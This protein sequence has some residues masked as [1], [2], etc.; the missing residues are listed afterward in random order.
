MRIG[1]AVD[2]T[3]DLPESFIRDN[4]IEILPITIR[5]GD[6]EIVDTHSEEAAREFYRSHIG[7]KGHDAESVPYTTEQICDTFLG[8]LVTEFDYVFCQTVMRTRSPIFE[9]ATKAS[10]S[11]LSQ[12]HEARKQAAVE[13][14]FALRVI[15]TGTVFTGQGVLAAETMR[16]IKA[17]MDGNH[18]R[19]S[20]DSLINCVRA[21]AVPPDLY[22]VRARARKK[23]DRSV[24]LVSAAL[25]SALD[26]KPIL[27]GYGDETKPV[28]KV[29]GFEPALEKLF[30]YAIR[31][32]EMGLMVPYLS[33]SYAGEL[34]DLSQF[35]R[36][37]DL[38][39]TCEQHEITLL[40]S[41]MSVTGGVN[42]GPGALSLALIAEPHT[43]Q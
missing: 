31:R 7:D 3:C 40:E 2:S 21:Y 30:N 15:N 5:L 13:G 26:I 29:R 1:L 19:K 10:F 11:I 35:P 6:T 4:N 39:T 33:I 42:I 34:D 18:I 38:K 8:R 14:P 22:Y 37:A 9:N 41:V 20:L 36:Y 28:D 12:Y 27:C 25:G 16:M 43:F 32:I 24:S 17:G 23:G